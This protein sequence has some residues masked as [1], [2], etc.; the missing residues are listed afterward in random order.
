MGKELDNFKEK[1]K[2]LPLTPGIYLMKNHTHKII[3]VGKAKVLRHRV[4][5]YFQKN[6][7]HSKKVAQMIFNIDDF[8]VIE[9][10]TELDA[11][12]LECQ[13]IQKY[14]PIYNHQMNY[15][16]NYPYVTISRTGFSTS[17]ESTPQ[18]LGPFRLYK[19]LPHIF[20]SLGELYQ[21][22]WM[23]YVTKLKSE[24]QLPQMKQLS[25]E[26]RLAEINDFF[27]GLTPTYRKWML[28]R[29]DFLANHLLFEQANLLTQQLQQLDYF[30]KQTQ[31]IN[32]LIQ[33]KSRIFSL[34]LSEDKNKYYQLA[35]GQIIHTEILTKQETFQ[36][37]ERIAKPIQLTQE[38]L[39][40]LLILLSYI[41]KTSEKG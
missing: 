20:E 14:H 12:L 22:P 30:F 38:R 17:F 1:V 6:Q 9:V 26:E 24:N 35:Y 37:L 3:Y 36:P 15:F 25:I 34:P 29:I 16:S 19:K 32:H 10:D 13:L 5:S 8:E 7:A 27:C 28:Q 40:P 2:N 11:L 33:E 21:M 31:E 39:D 18:S 4:Q 23:N 41:K